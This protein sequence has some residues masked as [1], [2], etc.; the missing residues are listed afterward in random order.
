MNGLLAA[1]ESAAVVI[2][3][4]LSFSTSVDAAC[5]RGAHV[6][7]FR[8][9]D[10][11]VRD[12]A[13][14]VGARVAAQRQ[15]DTRGV[16]SLSPPTLLK[17]G[18]GDRLVLPSPN[19]ST[20]STASA[21]GCTITACLRNVGAV[22]NHLDRNNKPIGVT[23]VAAGER[24]PDGSLRVALEDHIGAGALSAQLAGNKTSEALAA[25]AVFGAARD[26]LGEILARSMSGQELIGR[27][28]AQDVAFASML[29]CSETVPILR[30]GAYSMHS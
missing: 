3:D 23:I 12:Y 2:V 15:D 11:R 4:V 17:L 6:F 5:S 21:A 13:S 24:W 10:S 29:N 18:A 20:L 27:G 22:A 28:F 8:W 26:R 9:N 25:E 1:E 7:P 14:S 19:G 16:P 30:N